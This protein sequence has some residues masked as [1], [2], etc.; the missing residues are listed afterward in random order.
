MLRRRGG[1]RGYPDGIIVHGQRFD[2]HFKNRK[3]DA[4]VG[5]NRI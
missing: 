5:N 1:T 4:I 3:I 2:S